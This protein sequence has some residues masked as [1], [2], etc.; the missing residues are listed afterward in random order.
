[1]AVGTKPWSASEA[2]TASNT[3]VWPGSGRRRSSIHSD[4]S[5]KPT[6]PMMSLARSCPSSVMLVASDAPSEVG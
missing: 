2:S 6:S 3:R 4:S 5:P 1:M